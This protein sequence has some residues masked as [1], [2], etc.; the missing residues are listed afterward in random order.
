VGISVTALVAFVWLRLTLRRR[1]QLARSK[2]DP[3]S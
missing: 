3:I 1:I 2:V